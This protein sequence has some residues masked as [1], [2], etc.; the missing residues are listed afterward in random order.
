MSSREIHSVLLGI[1]EQVVSIC[2]ANRI[3][4]FLIGGGCLG[5]VRH[6]GGFVPWDDDLDL[7]VWA[8]DMPRL[9]EA[10]TEL[11]D[12]FRV[13][14]TRE[15]YNPMIRVMD[16]RTRTIG[17]DANGGGVF[18]EIIP[19]SHWRSRSWKAFDNYLGSLRARINK[20]GKSAARRL[21]RMLGAQRLVQIAETYL[22]ERMAFP[23]FARQDA[24]LRRTGRG[25]ISGACGR[26]WIGV[27]EHDVIY[28]LKSASFCGMTVNVPCDLERFLRVRYGPAFLEIPDKSERWGHFHRAEWVEHP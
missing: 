4:Y 1:L 7:A 20:D 21:T 17:T 12:R 10:L 3:E 13:Q 25:V 2:Q 19:A 8:G 27:Y 14:R 15:R 6:E 11:P 9:F 24:R 23:L 16:N 5:I 18:V 22:S 28:P 26:N